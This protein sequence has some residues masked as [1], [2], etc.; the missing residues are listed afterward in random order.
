MLLQT[1]AA[2][3]ALDPS[4]GVFLDKVAATHLPVPVGQGQPQMGGLFGSL[5]RSFAELDKGEEE[6]A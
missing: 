4:F 2:A 1:Y 6:G 3:L 5:L